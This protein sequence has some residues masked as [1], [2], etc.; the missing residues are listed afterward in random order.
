[1]KRLNWR[2]A[3]VFALL[4]L[5]AAGFAR[6]Y[7]D[8]QPDIRSFTP[9]DTVILQGI[10][11]LEVTPVALPRTVDFGKG[12]FALFE[13]SLPAGE[14]LRL[15]R[16]V[17]SKD[18]ASDSEM[19]EAWLRINGVRV[20]TKVLFQNNEAVFAQFPPNAEQPPAA[21]A[22]I[23]DTPKETLNDAQETQFLLTPN[24]DLP[25]V[26]PAGSEFSVGVY[27][28]WAPDISAR[29]PEQGLPD[30]ASAKA[31][32]RF[33]LKELSGTM[34]PS[35]DKAKTSLAQPMC[36]PYMGIQ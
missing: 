15:E 5:S 4:A 11:M 6:Q 30:G 14:E 24:G 29:T 19:P 25:R 21:S 34:L 1:M 36:W 12:K 17:I 13:V 20:Y 27:G 28:K 18:G 32:I 3:V 8:V 31:G 2:V 7:R 23:A 35:G 9:D 22:S 10:R 33:C 16:V 26:F